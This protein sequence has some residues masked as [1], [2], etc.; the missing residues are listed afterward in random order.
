MDILETGLKW[1]GL[2]Q[3]MEC[4]KDPNTGQVLPIH[5]DNKT[6]HPCVPGLMPSSE[7][8]DFSKASSTLRHLHREWSQEGNVER[9]ACFKPLTEYLKDHF[10]DIPRRE[11]HKIRILNP[12]CGLGRF[13][14]DLACMGFEAEGCEISYHML[15]GSMHMMNFVARAEQYQI[16]PF[17]LQGTNHLTHANRV[18]HI[19]V[20][21]IYPRDEL[22]EAANYSAVPG[23]ERLGISSGD[24]SVVYKQEEYMG[25]YDVVATIFFLDTAKNPLS[26]IETVANCLK[27][28]GIW[29]NLGPLKW[30]FE[31][32][33][34]AKREE[35]HTHSTSADVIDNNHE[36]Y[37]IAN[38][39][40]VLLAEEDILTLLAK[41][42][43]EMLKYEGIEA[44][45][46][47]YI[48]DQR[49]METNMFFPSFWVAKKIT[50]S[51]EIGL[52]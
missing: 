19:K 26:Y 16:H 42:G 20:P 23:S 5:F 3:L 6:G 43:F 11:W 12:G 10:K 31:P 36:D 40:V 39:G 8:V 46:T 45:P 24:F 27:P 14:F 48:H 37:G 29:M 50:S 32:W 34:H 47:G 13:V 7:H 38:P 51:T 18:R 1:A 28:G 21:D 44:H 17:A 30:H 2:E 41:Y 9:S 15:I 4:I 49:S 25:R 22:M 52:K 35:H 33:E